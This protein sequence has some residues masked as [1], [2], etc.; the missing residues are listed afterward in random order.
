MSR[1]R[2]RRDA[3]PRAHTQHGPSTKD[4]HGRS[5]LAHPTDEMVAG[6]TLS[7]V[8]GQAGREIDHRSGAVHPQGKYHRAP[9]RADTLAAALN[10]PTGPKVRRRHG[11]I[12]DCDEPA[13][14]ERI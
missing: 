1:Y 7:S 14:D 6:G 11:S 4:D 8:D 5:R 2:P 9:R 3:R 13:E 12:S 10:E